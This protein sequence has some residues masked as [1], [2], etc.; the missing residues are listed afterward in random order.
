[1]TALR[2]PDQGDRGAAAAADRHRHR[3]RLPPARQAR[4]RQ[5]GGGARRALRRD[6]GVRRDRPRSGDRVRRGRAA[7]PPRR[8]SGGLM[9]RVARDAPAPS[10]A[11]APRPRLPGHADQRPL[12]PERPSGRGRASLRA[13]ERVR[14]RLPDRRPDRPHGRRSDRRPRADPRRR[15]A[16]AGRGRAQRQHVH[17]VRAAPARARGAARECRSPSR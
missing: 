13:D 10:A 7:T 14:R 16:H 2:P 15:P 8:R 9:G 4:G 17:A 11:G 3:D 5:A 1:M 6:R 12:R